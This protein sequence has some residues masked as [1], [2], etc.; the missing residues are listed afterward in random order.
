[1]NI[2]CW[3]EQYY[4]SSWWGAA[5]AFANE[6][7]FGE[8]DENVFWISTQNNC[9][10]AILTFQ[11]F[12]T[13]LT[14]SHFPISRVCETTLN[15]DDAAYTRAHLSSKTTWDELLKD[16][17]LNENIFCSIFMLSSSSSESSSSTTSSW[18]SARSMPYSPNRADVPVPLFSPS[19]LSEL[20]LWWRRTTESFSLIFFPWAFMRRNDGED[21]MVSTQR[22]QA[23]KKYGTRL[24]STLSTQCVVS[25]MVCKYEKHNWVNFFSPLLLPSSATA[26]SG[27]FFGCCKTWEC[28]L[29]WLRCW[30]CWVVWCL[31]GRV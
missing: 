31:G 27:F 28:V 2:C 25:L 8:E 12:T 3:A 20:W 6:C 13:S 5:S 16:T 18:A 22:A 17:L 15:N 9:S 19:S 29:P 24:S 7:F 1:M 21:E 4:T 30:C 10:I 26:C 14:F 23:Q 11:Y